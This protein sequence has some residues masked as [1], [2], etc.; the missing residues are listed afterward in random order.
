MSKPQGG[1]KAVSTAGKAPKNIS[2]FL[3]VR[4]LMGREIN[5]NHTTANLELDPNDRTRLTICKKADKSSTA[6]SYNFNAVWGPNTPQRQVYEDCARGA[7]DA[8]F[9]GQ[10]GVLFVYGQTG[11]GKT[12]TISNEAPDNLGVLQQSM[13]EAWKRIHSDT[14]SD[15]SCSVS[16]VQLYNEILTDLLD[17]QKPR[18]QI[19]TGPKNDA[20]LVTESTGLGVAKAV[21]NYNETMTFFRQGLERKEMQST[22]MNST[23]S[24]SHT[25]FTFYINRSSKLGA[26]TARETT[27]GF[28]P[29][30]SLEGRV[31]LC[32]LA[33]SERVSK[34][35]AQGKTLDEAT[36]INTS[37]LVLGKV[38][39]ALIDK[40][41]QHA[42]FRESKLTRLLQYSLLGNG[43]TS[44][45]IN[46]SPSDD[47]TEETHSAIQFGQRAIQIKQEAK[48]HEVI[49]YK[50][51]YMQQQAD[52]DAKHDAILQSTL[53][54]AKEAYEDQ[55]AKLRENLKFAEDEN[56]MLRKEI[57]DLKSQDEGATP[58]SSSSEG[59]KK[60]GGSEKGATGGASPAS[61]P[62]RARSMTMGR[63]TDT[64]HYVNMIEELRQKMRSRDE[65]YEELHEQRLQ[66]GKLLSEEQLKTF[67]LAQ[68]LQAVT[69]RYNRDWETW[70][71]KLD[72]VNAELAKSRGTDFLTVSAGGG[73]GSSDSSAPLTSPRTSQRHRGQGVGETEELVDKLQDTIS[74]LRQEKRDL[75]VYQQLA[76]KAIRMLHAQG[77]V[78]QEQLEKATRGH[79]R[80]GSA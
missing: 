74:S 17:P 15:Y 58:A 72:E 5:G 53:N 63:T 24:R 55:I 28:V 33:G 45:V 9:E 64:S 78:L 34:T 62:G 19:Q 42:P 46:V 48:R 38:V 69:I 79:A 57:E 1:Q 29:N 50:A 75:I 13:M 10:H 16:Y 27:D 76:E 6:K 32:D 56:A 30:I 25:I 3:R 49:D 44:I 26:V 41:S 20:I 80:P 71:Q 77:L 4:P 22:D 66:L 31:V 59:G 23:S 47:N 60:A 11:S 65:K 8:A 14:G 18:V 70:S 67:R 21:S 61:P 40:K 51:L 35:N 54:E 39:A 37:L 36:H 73:F 7:V 52:F 43:N 12:F 68:Q 2:V